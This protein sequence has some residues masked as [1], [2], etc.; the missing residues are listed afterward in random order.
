LL[1]DVLGY[2]AAYSKGTVRMDNERRQK[3][4]DC[5]DESQEFRHVNMAAF[6]K[7]KKKKTNQ[8]ERTDN[9]P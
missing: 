6:K 8:K 4:R 3:S 2:P 5:Q 9:C 1:I 7:K